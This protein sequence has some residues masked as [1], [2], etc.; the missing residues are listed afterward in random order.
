MSRS[1]TSG[2]IDTNSPR[3]CAHNV[4]PWCRVASVKI[5]RPSMRSIRA[6]EP[7]RAVQRRGRP[8]VDLQVGG[9]A[10]LSRHRLHEAEH[11]VEARG[12]EAAVHAPGRP[13]VGRAEHDLA[14]D[15]TVVLR[16]RDDRRGERVERSDERAEVEEEHVLVVRQRGLGAGVAALVALLDEHRRG[17]LDEVAGVFELQVD[18]DRRVVDGDVPLRAL[19]STIG[20]VARAATRRCRARGRCAGRDPCGS[21]RRGSPTSCRACPSYMVLAEHVGEAP[22]LQLGLQLGALGADVGGTDELRRVVHVEVGGGDV[23]VAGDHH[24]LVGRAE[25]GDVRPQLGQPAQLVLVVL[26]VERAAVGHV[27][28]ADAHA[29]APR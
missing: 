1:N 23:E 28:A 27:H 12:D 7:Q 29:A 21:R 13:L 19:R 10:R 4:S 9:H 26:V 18:D 17:L 25:R 11:L 3:A 20:E 8:V 16:P 15:R 6:D 14:H 22:V 5:L 24:L 2:F